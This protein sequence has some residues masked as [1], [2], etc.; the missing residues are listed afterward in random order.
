MTS[1]YRP[2]KAKSKV[3]FQEQKIPDKYLSMLQFVY[4]YSSFKNFSKIFETT[5]DIF[6]INL[7]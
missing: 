5:I 7:F 2:K 6:L 1:I 4:I 3:S